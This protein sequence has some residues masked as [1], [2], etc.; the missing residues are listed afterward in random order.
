MTQGTG[1]DINGYGPML[2]QY[3]GTPNYGMGFLS[4][5][6]CY[7]PRLFST[8]LK[9]GDMFVCDY[10]QFFPDRY[11]D[12]RFEVPEYVMVWGNNP[13]VANSD[14]TLGH[15]IV[16]CM[17]RGSKIICM[18]PKLTWLA[19]KAEFWFQLRPGTD[20]ALALA[21]SNIIIKEDLYDHEFVELWTYGFD[22]V[23][24][25]HRSATPPIRPRR[26]AASTPKR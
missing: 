15:W 25:E 16:E 17:K 11:D 4:G 20:C 23:R 14:G 19:G 1:R 2:A 12:P 22:E 18:D 6:A 26:S 9:A 21:L 24:C 13:V 7:A 8:S 5:Q 3:L 10:S